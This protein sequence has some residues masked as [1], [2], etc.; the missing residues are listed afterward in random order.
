MFP[1]L[2]TKQEIEELKKKGLKE[3]VDFKIISSFG[4]TKGFDWLGDKKEERWEVSY[5]CTLT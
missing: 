2:K 5:P 3:G 1:I 4:I